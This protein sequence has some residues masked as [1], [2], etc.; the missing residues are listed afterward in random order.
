[1]V[2]FIMLEF[3]S[4]NIEVEYCDILLLFFVKK[5]SILREEFVEFFFFLFVKKGVMVFIIFVDDFFLVGGMF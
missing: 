3:N 5:G 1:M 4:E 2:I